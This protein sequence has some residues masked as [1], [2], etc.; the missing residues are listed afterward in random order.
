M[1]GG[2]DE[3]FWIFCLEGPVRVVHFKMQKQLKK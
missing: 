1:E 2:W 3:P